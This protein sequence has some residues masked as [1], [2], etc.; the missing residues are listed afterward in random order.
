M[1]SAT[2]DRAELASALSAFKGLVRK[3]FAP[4]CECLLFDA[5]PASIE[6]L[7]TDLDRTVSRTIPADGDKAGI[8]AVPYERLARFILSGKSADISL[9]WNDGTLS[10]QMGRAKAQIPTLKSGDF[11]RPERL[12]DG[13]RFTVSVAEINRIAAFCL[14]AASTAKDRFYLQGI[15]LDGKSAVA[16]NGVEMAVTPIVLLSGAPPAGQPIFPSELFPVFRSACDAA[17][18][19]CAIANY[20]VEFSW[21]GGFMASKLI[22]GSFPDW[23]R[24]VPNHDKAITCDRKGLADA[25]TRACSVA[26][27]DILGIVANG[28]LRLRAYSG[29][30]DPDAE[31]EIDCQCEAEIR[32][33]LQ[34]RA[35]A[36]AL[37]SLDGETVSI[38][39]VDGSTAIKL[40]GTKAGDYRVIMPLHA[41]FY[42][43][44][45][46]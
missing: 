45:R 17:E 11:P 35:L 6:I 34:G 21:T 41:R 7:G 44:P 39:A 43:E 14:D 9:K 19:E 38:A 30:P 4:I 31:D 28:E 13:D 20:R 22:D 16:T 46:A 29:G 15:C 23:A 42:P 24:A 40:T 10:L 25:A 36:D 18:V 37:S 33:G 27:V 12:T 8:F 5:K 1:Y 32:F 3:H 26:G 2:I